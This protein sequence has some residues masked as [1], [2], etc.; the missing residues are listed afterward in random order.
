MGDPLRITIVGFEIELGRR[1]MRS[2]RGVVH[3]DLLVGRVHDVEAAI[4]VRDSPGAG[5]TGIQV[6]VARRQAPAAS[7]VDVDLVGAVV[8]HVDAAT[9][10]CNPIGSGVCRIKAEVVR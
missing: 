8:Q 6:E 7:R 9:G 2:V 10:V 4:G 5:V 3:V 1:H